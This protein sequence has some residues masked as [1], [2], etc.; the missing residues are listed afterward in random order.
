MRVG[1]QRRHERKRDEP[2]GTTWFKHPRSWVRIPPAPL[3]EQIV[4]AVAQSGKREIVSSRLVV[5]SLSRLAHFTRCMKA[6]LLR[7]G[8]CQR[9]YMDLAVAGSSPAAGF[10]RR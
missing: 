4:G 8:E 6:T 9:N 2:D 5:T 3:I 10:G 1:L 7:G